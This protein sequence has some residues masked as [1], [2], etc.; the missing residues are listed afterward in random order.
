MAETDGSLRIKDG[1]GRQIAQALMIE[2][3]EDFGQGGES[4]PM[5]QL[6]GYYAKLVV[7][8]EQTPAVQQ[9]CFPALGLE[10]WGNCFRCV[11]CVHTRLVKGVLTNTRARLMH[12]RPC[13][14]VKR[15]AQ[16][17]HLVWTVG[18]VVWGGSDTILQQDLYSP[19]KQY[20]KQVC[21]FL[22]T[23]LMSSSV[24]HRALQ[25]RAPT[26]APAQHML[27]TQGPRAVPDG[28]GQLPAPHAHTAPV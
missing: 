2:V 17:T 8:L 12:S 9:T 23:H 1:R 14:L 28:Q 11:I 13:C 20:N 15:G 19:P 27:H 16:L 10:V 4:N 21:V 18:Y 24:V 26:Q 25:P 22:A 7:D 6:M 5:M 3:K